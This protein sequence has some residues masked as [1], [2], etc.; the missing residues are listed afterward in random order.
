MMATENK[1]ADAWWKASFGSDAK[2]KREGFIDKYQAKF[3]NSDS[4]IVRVLSKYIIRGFEVDDGSVQ[5][6]EFMNFVARFGPFDSTYQKAKDSLFDDKSLLLPWFHGSLSREEAEKRLGSSEGGHYLVRYS[7]KFP[8]KLTIMYTS[9]R[10]AS[11]HVKN[12]LVH[13]SE[14]GFTLFDGTSNPDGGTDPPKYFTSLTALIESFKHKLVKP[15][16]SPI[17]EYIKNND[18]P[19]SKHQNYVIPDFTSS[20]KDAKS[21]D[22]GEKGKDDKYHVFSHQGHERKASTG[23]HAD[24]AKH[25]EYSKFPAKE[26]DGHLSVK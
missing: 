19:G 9:Q 23:G 4:Y 26:K 11:F 21:S 20:G 8:T 25:A 14:K 18:Q 22:K 6:D 10:D 1:D 16:P 12:I 3:K 2:T 13:N 5:H 7:E 17:L 24:G 15:V